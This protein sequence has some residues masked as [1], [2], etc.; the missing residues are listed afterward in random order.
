MLIM[1][2]KYIFST[3]YYNSKGT[4]FKIDA[5]QALVI[6]Y[7]LYYNLSFFGI[8]CYYDLLLTIINYYNLS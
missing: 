6:I 5:N 2:Y 7:Y 1:I 3:I 8:H 4:F